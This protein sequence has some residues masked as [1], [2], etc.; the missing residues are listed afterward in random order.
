MSARK[1]TAAK[2]FPP[3]KKQ[4]R[5]GLAAQNHLIPWRAARLNMQRVILPHYEC[6]RHNTDIERIQHLRKL[7]LVREV[8]L[9]EVL[10]LGNASDFRSG[11]VR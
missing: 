8:G 2:N 10:G 5:K 9:E 7:R 3:F 4:L 11:R 6:E 1:Q